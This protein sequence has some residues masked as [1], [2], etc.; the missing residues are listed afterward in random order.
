ML[1]PQIFSSLAPMYQSNLSSVLPSL[2]G[3]ALRCQLSL[4]HYPALPIPPC[5]IHLHYFSP[6]KNSKS[7]VWFCT[8]KHWEVAP[9]F[10]V[11]HHNTH[12]TMLGILDMILSMTDDSGWARDSK[13]KEGKPW[14]NDYYQDL[15]F[16]I[17]KNKVMLGITLSAIQIYSVSHT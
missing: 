14:E 1:N 8:N 10:L 12:K 15:I 4:I 3:S 17:N 13:S 6:L 5:R 2:E 11:L 7:I 9:L 16:F